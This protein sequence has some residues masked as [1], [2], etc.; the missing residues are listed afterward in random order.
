MVDFASVRIERSKRVAAAGLIVVCLL[1]ALRMLGAERDELAGKATTGS[2][3][4]SSFN[5]AMET[6]SMTP[7]FE[8]TSGYLRSVLEYLRIPA[9]SQIVVFSSASFQA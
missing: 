4:I 1:L 3:A 7:T 6:G 5:A 9:E 2:S 8:P